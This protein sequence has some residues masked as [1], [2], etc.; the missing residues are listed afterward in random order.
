MP[1][2]L[3]V[4]NSLLVSENQ[5][6]ILAVTAALQRLAVATKVCLDARSARRLLDNKK[7]EAIMVDFDLGENAP[8]LLSRARKSTSNAMVPTI[9]ITRTQSELSLAHAVGTNFIVQRPFTSETL[10]HTLGASYGLVL[11][12]RR[13]Y[14]RCPVRTRA[15]LRRASM[16][17]APC[18]VSNVSEGG[19]S[20]SSVPAHLTAGMGVTVNFALPGCRGTFAAVCEVRWRGKNGRAGLRFILMPLDQ[21]CDL[22]DWLARKLEQMLPESVAQ[23]FRDSAERAKYLETH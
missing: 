9:A 12:E 23:R 13:R 18:K 14:F 22:Q 6:T 20:L 17:E 10:N 16:K 4:A 15:L 3:S 11:R 8:Q 5:P 7:F 19:M 1:A 21:R 2:T